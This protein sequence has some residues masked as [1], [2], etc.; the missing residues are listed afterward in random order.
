MSAWPARAR[1]RG[2]NTRS[3]LTTGE[4]GAG[5]RVVAAAC[6]KLMLPLLAR[7]LQVV[8]EPSWPWRGVAEPISSRFPSRQVPA[9]WAVWTFPLSPPAWRPFPPL[10]AG[11]LPVPKCL[12]QPGLCQWGLGAIPHG[13]VGDGAAGGDRWRATGWLKRCGRRMLVPADL[14]PLSPEGC[15]RGSWQ[16]LRQSLFLR[17]CGSRLALPRWGQLLVLRLSGRLRGP[18]AAPPAEWQRR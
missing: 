5:R 18:A 11:Y 13:W 4:H 9:G 6:P 12:R 14:P 17:P 8:A 10:P 16:H 3:S 2:W 7:T 1:R 15:G